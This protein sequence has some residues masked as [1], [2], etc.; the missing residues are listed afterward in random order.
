MACVVAVKELYLGRMLQPRGAKS[1]VQWMY[2]DFMRYHAGAT[3]IPREYVRL[4]LA[5]NY[6]GE[7]VVGNATD[8]MATFRNILTLKLTSGKPVLCGVRRD[9]APYGHLFMIYGYTLPNCL[10]IADPAFG[11]LNNVPV[12]QIK[13][14][15][16]GNPAYHWTHLFYTKR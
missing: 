7:E 3:S 2:D 6:D 13:S 1:P 5:E 11:V 14:G 4:A 12:A 9:G 8:E 15:Y 10:E 16:N